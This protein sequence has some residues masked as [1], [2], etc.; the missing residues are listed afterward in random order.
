MRSSV[1]IGLYL[2]IFIMFGLIMFN[3]VYSF[4]GAFLKVFKYIRLG[5]SK[6]LILRPWEPSGVRQLK[7]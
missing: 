4:P 5:A 7:K 1:G 2:I 3:F 6:L